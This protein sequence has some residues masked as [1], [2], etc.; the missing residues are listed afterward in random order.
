MS[1]MP[2]G[3]QNFVVIGSGVSAP[4]VRDFA[5]TLGWL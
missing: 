5:V 3:M 2:P 1:W 4:H